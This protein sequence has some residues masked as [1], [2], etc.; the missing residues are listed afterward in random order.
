MADSKWITDLA[1]E[2]PL[3]AA[4]RQVLKARLATVADRLPDA[5]FRAEDNLEHVHQLRVGTRRAGAAIRIFQSCLSAKTHKAI[6]K[7]LRKIR[8]AAGQARDWD[9]FQVALATR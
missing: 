1:G 7:T 4:A 9:V 3:A 8:R 2:V 5:L 6:R